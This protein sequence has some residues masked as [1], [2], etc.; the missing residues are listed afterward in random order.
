MHAKSCPDADSADGHY[1]GLE[2]FWGQA[3][4]PAARISFCDVSAFKLHSILDDG[5]LTKG[6][7]ILMLSCQQLWPAGSVHRKILQQ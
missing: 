1:A 6:S 4:A 7:I 5:Y 2:T 3:V